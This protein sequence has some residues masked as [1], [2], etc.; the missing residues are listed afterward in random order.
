MFN[1]KNKNKT[2][3][4]SNIETLP[5]FN[6][7]NRLVFELYNNP[8]K[9][10]H[11]HDFNDLAYLRVA[12]PYCDIVIC[13]KYWRDRVMY[14]KLHEKYQTDVRANLLDLNEL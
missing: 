7:Y 14:H 5:G 10:V 6:I 13:E 12:V 9:E 1:E 3:T 8:H 11:Q 4:I 2:T